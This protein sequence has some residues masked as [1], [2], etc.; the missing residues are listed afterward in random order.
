MVNEYS[1]AKVP[2][3]DLERHLQAL[4]GHPNIAVL[5][6]GTA[7]KL[8]L[9][10]GPGTTD[11]VR[12]SKVYFGRYGIFGYVESRRSMLY[13]YGTLTEEIRDFSPS[14]WGVIEI[15]ESLWMALGR[16][17]GLQGYVQGVLFRN[18]KLRREDL[19]HPNIRDLTLFDSSYVWGLAPEI[20]S[21]LWSRFRYEVE[22]TEK[23]IIGK[24]ETLESNLDR[25]IPPEKRP[26]FDNLM[27]PPGE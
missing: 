13:P 11:L 2:K 12:L 7:D 8:V 16:V 21:V 15:P 22:S 10:K 3:A 4:E 27:L 1:L 23:G 17:E 14:I 5:A 26:T 20:S 9:A 25:I 24:I 6:E 18:D 19:N